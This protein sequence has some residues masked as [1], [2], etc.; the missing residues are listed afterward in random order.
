[1]GNGE[2][3]IFQTFTP[4]LYIKLKKARGLTSSYE[5]QV[6]NHTSSLCVL[7]H[8]TITN[9]LTFDLHVRT[10]LIRVTLMVCG[11]RFLL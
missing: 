5:P 4:I 9:K 11:L 8:K 10:F 2:L 1:M 7:S 3:S 6:R